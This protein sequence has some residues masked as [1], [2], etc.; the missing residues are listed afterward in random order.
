MI[1]GCKDCPDTLEPDEIA[2]ELPQD[3]PCNQLVSF[4]F[5]VQSD[6]GTN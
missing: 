3:M 4:I 1:F 6:F 2:S 5:K